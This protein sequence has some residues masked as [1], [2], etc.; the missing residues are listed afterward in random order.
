MRWFFILLSDFF[1]KVQFVNDCNIIIRFQNIK[2]KREQ[3]ESINN[4]SDLQFLEEANNLAVWKI[5][6]ITF[7]K[8]FCFLYCFNYED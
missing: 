2:T 5:G 4:I 1:S 6:H 8:E 7:C 3:I